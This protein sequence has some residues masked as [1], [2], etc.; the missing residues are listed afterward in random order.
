MDADGIAQA[1]P[2]PDTT[3]DPGHVED[4]IFRLNAAAEL[5]HA[6]TEPLDDDA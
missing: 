3:D 4:I 2:E 1:I 6:M 5:I